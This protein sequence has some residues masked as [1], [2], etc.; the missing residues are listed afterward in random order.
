MKFSLSSS[1]P[2]SSLV[3]IFM[4]FLWV[5]YQAIYLSLFPL[6]LFFWRFSLFLWEKLFCLFILFDFSMVVYM[7]YTK[8]AISV[9]KKWPYVEAASVCCVPG[10]FGRP[11]EAELCLWRLW[12][13]GAGLWS[14]SSS[15]W[16]GQVHLVMPCL[17]C[18]LPLSGP[19]KC[20][21]VCPGNCRPEHL[22]RAPT[23][24]MEVEENGKNGAHWY[25]QPRE[26]LQLLRA[27]MVSQP[28]LF[29]LFLLSKA[30]HSA[31][32][33][34]GVIA[35]YKSAWEGASPA[36]YTAAILDLSKRL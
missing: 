16:G 20:L 15:R 17:C 5:P 4:T 13:W 14:W 6:G 23:Y 22:D 27:P 2:L 31:L 9:L 11:V 35:L 30:V 25:L 21:V 28:S 34:L 36:S 8:I 33:Y 26:F 10:Y 7:N 1:I 18:L 29:G 3:S 12:C 24:P 32:N 19:E